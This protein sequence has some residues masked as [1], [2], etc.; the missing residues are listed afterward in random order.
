MGSATSYP[1]S[2][3]CN[4]APLIALGS[5]VEP[6]AH[7]KPGA[8]TRLSAHPDKDIISFALH[9]SAV[10]SAALASCEASLRGLGDPILHGLR[11]YRRS[12]EGLGLRT[13]VGL[14]QAL[15]V[16]PLSAAL[17]TSGPCPRSLAAEATRLVLSSSTEASAEYYR[18][19]RVVSP[20]HLGRYRG[21]LPDVGGGEPGVGLG[22][23]LKSVRWD[24]VAWELTTGYPLTLKAVEAIGSS[25]GVSDAGVS[26]ALAVVLTESGDTL[27]ARKWGVR[28]YLASRAELITH[29]RA[30]G[31]VR[32]MELLDPP[33][34][35]RGWSPGSALDVVS[36]AIGLYLVSEALS[37]LG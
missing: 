13:N 18:A 21:S 3:L 24:L 20:S 22:E 26:I 34:R 5:I 32:A 6:L 14:G 36:A 23:L 27:I 11:T 37:R 28:A 29:S 35:S 7:P 25:G 8:V 31:P 2:D 33:W 9:S 16:V 17:P 19:I 1:S 30:L 4:L 12:L 10:S 15:M